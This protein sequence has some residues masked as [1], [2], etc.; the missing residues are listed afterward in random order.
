MHE[1]LQD[2]QS[3]VEPILYLWRPAASWNRMLVVWDNNVRVKPLLIIE[4]KNNLDGKSKLEKKC[5]SEKNRGK[6][7]S[8]WRV[9]MYV[10]VSQ[11]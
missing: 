7:K 8:L 3:T 11:K 9:G 2:H 6:L 10:W 4:K 5:S 1:E